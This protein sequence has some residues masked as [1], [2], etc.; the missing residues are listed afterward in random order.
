MLARN[1]K[2]LVFLPISMIGENSYIQ[3]SRFYHTLPGKGG[4]IDSQ[5]SQPRGKPL[6]HLAY[7]ISHKGI[8]GLGVWDFWFLIGIFRNLPLGPSLMGFHF[9]PVFSCRNYPRSTLASS[10]LFVEEIL[11]SH[12]FLLSFFIT[13]KICFD[14]NIPALPRKGDGKRWFW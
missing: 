1:A 12:Q 13:R 10:F 5:L 9:R 14:E 4:F 7:E 8:S 3:I 11:I 2:F 6:Q